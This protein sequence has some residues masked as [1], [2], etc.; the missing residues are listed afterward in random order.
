MEKKLLEI[1]DY[2]FPISL[3]F[4]QASSA[5][6]HYLIKKMFGLKLLLM[7]WWLFS[8]LSVCF[9]LHTV[10]NYKTHTTLLSL[11]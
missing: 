5:V 2:F 3:E 9:F 4:V 6:K 1:R 11:Y 8:F 7:Y 10:L